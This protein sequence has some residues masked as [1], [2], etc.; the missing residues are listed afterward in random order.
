MYMCMYCMSM[1]LLLAPT[2][3]V[4]CTVT[5]YCQG[6]ERVRRGVILFVHK[7][8]FAAHTIAMSRVVMDQGLR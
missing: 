2:H 6:A 3:T 8:V 1:P 7:D 4:S 5:H